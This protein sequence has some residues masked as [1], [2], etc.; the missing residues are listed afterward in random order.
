MIDITWV[1]QVMSIIDLTPSNIDLT[2]SNR[3]DP[4]QEWHAALLPTLHRPLLRD[5]NEHTFLK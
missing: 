2:P 3:L 1:S 5:Q 4:F